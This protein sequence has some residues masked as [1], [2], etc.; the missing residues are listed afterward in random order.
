MAKI[1]DMARIVEKWKRVAAG[2]GPEYEEGIRNP[3]ADWETETKAAEA[4]YEA[5]VSAA[6]A[7][8]GFGKG[9]R[10]AGTPK[11]QAMSLA[12]GPGRWSQGIDLSGDAY[13]AGFEPYAR[14]IAALSLPPRGP[15][16]DP[17]NIARV[18]AVAKALHDAKIARAGG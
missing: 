10:K 7:R 4:R 1:K 17:R 18:A 8:K 14:V 15:K 16:G 11:W 5:G 6:I 2:A 13:Q 12:K 9:V 3:K